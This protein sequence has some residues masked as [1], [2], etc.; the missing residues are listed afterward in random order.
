MLPRILLPALLLF[1]ACHSTT[2][3][4]AGET[5]VPMA[6]RPKNIILLIGDGMATAQVSAGL[7]W[8]G[9]GKSVWEQF[10]VVG[11]HKSHSY[12]EKVTDSAAGATAF[13]CGQKTKNNG[14]GIVPPDYGPCVT[15]LEEL[16]ARGWA[17]GMVVSCSATHATPASFISHVDIRAFTEA[18]ADDFLKTPIDCFVGGGKGYFDDRPDHKNLLDSL[19]ARGYEIRTGYSFNRLPLDG[20]APFM[21]FTADREPPSAL[22]GRNYMPTA[23][24]KVCP[25]LEKRSRR[26]F[27]LM[28]EG[29][30]IDWALHSNQPDWL[31]A[32]MMDFDATIQAALRFAA[33]NGE[34]LVIVTG[35][36]ECGGMGLNEASRWQFEPTFTARLHSATMVPVFAY[37][38]KSELFSG[39]YENTAIY[40]KMWAALGANKVES[41]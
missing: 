31:K 12:D 5:L 11:F 15:I 37:G 24:D 4:S 8:K 35:D 6:E 39:I 20:S 23:V 3:V 30:Q 28:V 36:H 1:L 2:G 22:S 38:P 9:P 18:I 21:L 14:I 19:D 17:T 33:S 7:Y 27:F 25:Y 41:K 16:D 29:S 34:T 13:A 32:E 10:P 40:Y 26:G